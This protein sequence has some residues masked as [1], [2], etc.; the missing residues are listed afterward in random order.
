MSGMRRLASGMPRGEFSSFVSL[1][2]LLMASASG[3]LK[4]DVGNR[5]GASEMEWSSPEVKALFGTSGGGGGG[6]GD[7]SSP[8][9]GDDGGS[10]TPVGAIAGGVIGGI[11]AIAA[12]AGIWWFLRRRKQRRGVQAGGAAPEPYAGQGPSEVENTEWKHGKPGYYDYPVTGTGHHNVSELQA[13]YMPTELPVGAGHQDESWG[14]QH[15]SEMAEG[16]GEVTM[17][18]HGQGR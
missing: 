13:G 3:F 7:S 11:A 4:T 17:P 2:S 10:S 5:G 16:Q 15:R 1:P 8:E 12:A 6:G 18:Q 14:H 9:G